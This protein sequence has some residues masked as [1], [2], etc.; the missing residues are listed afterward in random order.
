MGA[1]GFKYYEDDDAYDFMD[2]IEESKSPKELIEDALDTAIESDFIDSTEGNAVIVSATYI[3]R[4]TKGTKFSESD[5][6][7]ILD[8]DTFPERNPNIDLSDLKENAVLALK[9]LLGEDSEL[10]ELWLE[11]EEDYPSWRQGIEKL[12]ERLT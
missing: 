9:K 6:G 2:E 1:W 11:N 3:D 4:Q 10:N 8:V 7:E 5:T 12:I